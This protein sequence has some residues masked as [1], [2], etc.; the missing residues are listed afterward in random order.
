MSLRFEQ[1]QWLGAFALALAAASITL[2]SAEAS[3]P[4]SCCVPEISRIGPSFCEKPSC[5]FSTAARVYAAVS[6]PATVRPARNP[7]S[8]ASSVA[9][10]GRFMTVTT[11]SNTTQ[12]QAALQTAQAGDTVLLAAGTYTPIQ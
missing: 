6:A 2:S 10:K 12:L 1:N 3:E 8:P 11:V 5:E 9:A 4:G 7:S